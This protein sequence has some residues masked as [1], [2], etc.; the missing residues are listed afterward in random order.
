MRIATTNPAS[1][2]TA[3]DKED[4]ALKASMLPGS[5]IAGVEVKE[6]LDTWAV[7]LSEDQRPNR[8][9]IGKTS[10]TRFTPAMWAA[11]TMHEAAH[12]S[13]TF[14]TAS[15]IDWPEK[16]VHSFTNILE[17][18]R[19]E[20]DLE[21]E[22]PGYI[23]SFKAVNDHAFAGFQRY[24]QLVGNTLQIK[25]WKDIFMALLAKKLGRYQNARL[26]VTAPTQEIELANG[27]MRTLNLTKMVQDAETML[28]AYVNQSSAFFAPETIRRSNNR[29][30]VN[31]LNEFLEKYSWLARNEPHTVSNIA[32]RFVRI[33]RDLGLGASICDKNGKPIPMA[34]E[35]EKQGK[36]T[37]DSGDHLEA[38]ERDKTL[39][40]QTKEIN[41][42]LEEMA[43]NPGQLEKT[44]PNPGGSGS[45]N[46]TLE[47]LYREK[48]VRQL[49]AEVQKYFPVGKL[50]GKGY[51]FEQTTRKR[52]QATDGD[53]SLDAVVEYMASNKPKGMLLAKDS[54][55]E[56][57]PSAELQ[58]PPPP[59]NKFPIKRL[60]IYLDL[61][62]SM[63]DQ[64]AKMIA[65][66]SA[67]AMFARKHKVDTMFV[68]GDQGTGL[69]R[70]G[71]PAD[72]L[73]VL[74]KEMGNNTNNPT[75]T[76]ASMNEAA[77]W[78]KEAGKAGRIIFI[79]DMVIRDHERDFINQIV[80]ANMGVVVNKVDVK[81]LADVLWMRQ[82]SDIKKGQT[83]NNAP[84]ID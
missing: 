43:P 50:P 26:E 28:D 9:L 34:G 13:A 16:L 81:E 2:L 6:G 47:S 70:K 27:T 22:Y 46:K 56:R 44:A 14:Y 37:Q 82:P 21:Q 59:G 5:T 10:Q 67:F 35:P 60:A 54:V 30:A 11:L 36:E 76:S 64:V 63:Y 66:S 49:L 51:R 79:T 83:K 3:K 80:Q 53:L 7:E 23:P 65:F 84:D 48:K 8:I 12:S 71:N 31:K 29:L 52:F 69:V 40:E 24:G 19:I 75:W 20:N 45:C 42:L 15:H 62:S 39:E 38:I 32:V 68:V 25:D 78:A 61:S 74:K 58:R 77:K 55:T 18:A 73:G 72:M 33:V 17:D 41:E 1:V 4:I 57:K